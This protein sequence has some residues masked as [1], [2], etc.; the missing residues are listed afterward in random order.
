M[1]S[2]IWRTEIFKNVMKVKKGVVGRGRWKPLEVGEEK[3]RVILCEY[4]GS[5]F[6]A[7]MKMTQ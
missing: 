1:F 4:D 5:V 6:Y 2:L 3:E 7:Y